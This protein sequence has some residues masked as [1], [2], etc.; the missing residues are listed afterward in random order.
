MSQSKRNNIIFY[1]I[2]AFIVVLSISGTAFAIYQHNKNVDNKQVTN[3]PKEEEDIT[4][5]LTFKEVSKSNTIDVF[6]KY[7]VNPIKINYKSNDKITISGLKNKEI[8]NKINEKLSV[9][10]GTRTENGDSLCYMHFNVSNVLSISCS[11]SEK[12]VN[13]N[14]VTGD[15]IELEDIFDKDTDIYSLLVKSIYDTICGWE[16]C[17]PESDRDYNDEYPSQVENKVVNYLE[18]IKNKEYEITLFDNSVRLNYKDDYEEGSGTYINYYDFS[19]NI[20]IYDRFIEDSI[21]ENKVTDYCVANSCYEQQYFNTKTAKYQMDYLNDKAYLY[22]AINNNTDQEAVY[23]YRDKE[24]I[25]INLD[26]VSEIVKSEIIKKENLQLKGNNY[27]VYNIDANIYYHTENDF[28]VVYF[29]IKKEFNKENFI[30]YRLGFVEAKTISEKIVTRVNML[31]DKNNKIT[32]ISDNPTKEISNF[33]NKLY[34]YIINDIRSSDNSSFTGYN[35]CEFSNDDNCEENKDYHNLI[36]E[37]SYAIDTVNNRLY[38][39]EWKPGVAVVESYVSAFIPLDIFKE[40]PIENN[41]ENTTEE[42][43][44]AQDNNDVIQNE[45]E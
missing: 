16:T 29:I 36:K 7:P 28:Q 18:R 22:Y 12:A 26:K 38:M 42:D 6:K 30:K 8:E 45:I 14:L 2:L 34:D 4:P 11:G 27:I 40:K 17:Y 31:I 19:D 32:Y 21:Y 9:L 39:Y 3:T 44:K 25:S 10:K 35:M 37:A 1:S 33:E 13:V 24:I 43:N 23:G 15:Y 5:Y 20:A 41:N